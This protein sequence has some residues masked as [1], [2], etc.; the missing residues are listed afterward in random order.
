MLQNDFKQRSTVWKTVVVHMQIHGVC[1][2]LRH[3]YRHPLQLGFFMVFILPSP[4][5]IFTHHLSVNFQHF[6]DSKKKKK[7]KGLGNYLFNCS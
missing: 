1:Q 6:F 3:V 5:S 7:K 2:A 4:I